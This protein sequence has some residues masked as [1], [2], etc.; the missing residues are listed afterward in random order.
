MKVT[1]LGSSLF[2]LIFFSTSSF[3]ANRFWIGVLPGN[4]NNTLN[5]SATSGGLITASVP[6]AGDI[7]VFDGGLGL[8]VGNC[9]ID[10]PVSITSLTV[11]LGYTG[12]IIQGANTI[13]ITGA[14]IFGG[15]TFTGGSANI[16]VTGA[17]TVSATA[18]TSTSA[19]L[20]LK[21]NAAFTGGNFAHNNGTV[22]FNTNI[23]LQTISG[24]SPTFYQLE[25]VGQGRTY[26]ISSA[27]N[28]TVTNNLIISGVGF[29][30]LT[31][32]VIDVKGDINVTNSATGCGGNAMINI[33]GTVAQNFSGSSIAGAGALPQLTI[34]KTAG[35]L[36]LSNFPAVSD[37]FTYTAGTVNA[38]TSTFCFTHGTITPYSITG[39]VSLTGIEFFMNTSTTTITLAAATVLT[40]TGD[41][42]IAGTGGVIINSGNINVDGNILLASTSTGGGG[43]TTINIVGTGAETMDGTA[44]IID[45]SRLPNININKASGTLLLTGNISFSDNVTYTAGTVNAGTS[46]CYIVNNL[47]M[48]GSFSLYNLTISAAGNTTL[49]IASGTTVTATN[50]LDLENGANYITINTGTIAAQGNIIDNNSSTIGGGNGTILI[51]GT[52]AQAIT[53]T[54]IADQGKFPAVTINKITGIVTFP[55]LITVVGNWTYTTGTFDVASNN[56]TIIFEGDLTI[57]GNHSLK[58]IKFE[59]SNNYTFTTAPATTL[60]VLGNMEIAGTFNVTLATGTI[61]LIGD[62]NLTNTSTGDGGTT[63]IAF[64]G[65]TNQAIHSTL[66]V[67]QSTLPAITIDKPSGTLTFPAL[68]T[69]FGNWTYVT[70]LYDVTL[71]NSTIEFAGDVI[72]TG[73][74]SLNNVVFEA[75]NNWNFTVNTGTILT[76]TGTLTTTGIKNI[77]FITPVTGTTAIQAQGDIIINNTSVTG[78]GTA[79]ILINGS[80][81]QAITGNAAASEGLLPFIKIQK[82]SGTLT[83][84]GIISVARDWTWLSGTVL[85]TTS[86]LIFGGNSLIITSAGMSFYKVT[87]TAN[88]NTLA[89]SLTVLNNL[90][91]TGAAILA[92]GAN[93][94]NLAGNWSNWGTGGFTEAT[95]TVNFNGGSLQTITAP[96]GENFTNVDINNSGAGIQL[97]N[98][99][100]IAT[101]L[102]MTQGNIDLNSKSI[103]LG[104]SALLP[105]TLNRTLGTMTNTGSF[106]RW[107]AK[108]TI[109]AGAVA[110]LF[111]VGTVND[112]RPFNVSIP[113][114]PTTGGTIAVAY[115]NA[116]TNTTTSFPDGIDVIMVRKD[117]N[118]GVTESGLAGGNYNLEISG[119]NYGLIGSVTDLRLTLVASVAGTPGTNAGT[120]AD[121]QVN[122]TGIT[123]AT[124]TNTFY[125]GSINST[126]SPL[127]ITLIQFTAVPQNGQVKLDWETSAEVNN[128]YFTVQRSNHSGIW[129]NI[130]KVD[131]SGS[132]S[133]NK[134]YEAYDPNPYSGL[135]FYRLEQTDYDGRSSYSMI[136]Q[137]N[138]DS[139]ATIRIYPNP[140][141]N[142]I[143]ISGSGAMVISVHN[144]NGQLL[145]TPVQLIRSE[146]LINVAAL[147]PGIYFIHIVQNGNQ[148]TTKEI[149]KE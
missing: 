102:T 128:N 57:S 82:P 39:T 117:L 108:S 136:R 96:A 20:E 54:G 9:T 36:T 90:N 77:F 66:L 147:P 124:L 112:Y 33:N 21:D 16:T 43:S 67:N 5:W 125:L 134:I 101:S 2:L 27:G 61:N 81:S 23:A 65:T 84:N 14:A 32:G 62:L 45:Q 113:V 143:Y 131:G 139:S 12:T 37:N 19:I 93:T 71:N 103:S 130:L 87:I 46:D 94:I 129:E 30:N 73:S 114:A 31:T 63:V 78:G 55:S 26:S 100:A 10:V 141:T 75:T 109:A 70:G 104:T 140:V 15:G 13:A 80:G 49:T 122:R 85:P 133:T 28:I 68:I 11:S 118:W 95:S 6:V 97:I 142:F 137:V 44:I 115:T 40:A 51:N 35:T 111:P 106:T 53:T 92:P 48:T 145:N 52:G 91:I 107:F 132:T 99:V 116:T 123:A 127:P 110:G 119:T 38:G 135:S 149:I 29:N 74:H 22:R 120:V 59:G 47:T 18:F 144:I 146:Y 7:V 42:T 60:T 56:S 148:L 3:A 58:N 76:V 25:F 138:F 98:T 17:F 83:L 64:T 86:S 4:W 105:G 1:R 121:P 88:T 79:L 89:N 50:I 126:S 41:L 8:S 72:F 24:T 69:V 34:N